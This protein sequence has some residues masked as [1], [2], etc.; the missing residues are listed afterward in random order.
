MATK[1]WHLAEVNECL[2]GLD[3]KEHGFLRPQEG[4]AWALG[5]TSRL[6]GADTGD[7]RG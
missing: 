2:T 5:M 7:R 3:L 1:A 4:A 6:P